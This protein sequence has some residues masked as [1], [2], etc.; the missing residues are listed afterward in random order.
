MTY[1]RINIS[2]VGLCPVCQQ[3]MKFLDAKSRASDIYEDSYTC[4]NCCLI[5]TYLTPDDNRG[6]HE[7]EGHEIE[8]ELERQVGCWG[9]EDES[10]S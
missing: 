1:A 9:K 8:V 7:Y 3:E 4:D 2:Y 5:V 10:Q 6:Y